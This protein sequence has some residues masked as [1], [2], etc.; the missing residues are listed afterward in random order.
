MKIKEILAGVCLLYGLIL[1]F[2]FLNLP[3]VFFIP[4]SIAS[5]EI[6]KLATAALLFL[7]TYFLLKK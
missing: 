6:G 5:F 4:I 2:S 3:V 7:L 1:F